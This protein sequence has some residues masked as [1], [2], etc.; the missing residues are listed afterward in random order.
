MARHTLYGTWFQMNSRCYN[1]EHHAYKNY[2]GRHIQVC[3]EWRSGVYGGPANGLK[4]YVEYIERHL[5]PKPSPKHT[6]DRVD[7][8]DIYKPGNL[9]WA[10]RRQQ[11]LN[12]RQFEKRAA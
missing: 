9:Q 5:G 3:Y 2:G 6:V 10:T 1:P 11:R 8:D 7:N 12:Q 4:N